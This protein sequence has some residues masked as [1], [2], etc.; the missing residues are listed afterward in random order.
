VSPP[1]P[2][3]KKSRCLSQVP[4]AETTAEAKASGTL[5]RRVEIFA[6]WL[7]IAP[8]VARLPSKLAYRAACWRGD[9]IF[10]HRPEEAAVITHNLHKFFGET[11]SPAEAERMTRE[12][13][14][15]S[16]CEVIDIMSLGSRVRPLRKLVEIRG[17]E[18]LEAAI[19][20]GKGAI[21][22]SAHLGSYESAFSMVHA[23][24]FPVTDIGQWWWNYLPGVSSA[25][26]RFWNYVHTRRIQRYRQRPNIEPWSGGIMSAMQAL[27]ALRHNEVVTITIDAAPWKNQARTVKVP[28]LGR[29]AALLPGVVTL[30]RSARAPILM[31]FVY[32][33]EDYRHQVVEISP[34]LS[35]E[36]E[37]ATVLGR[38]AAAME[39]AIS[40][41][42]AHWSIWAAVDGLSAIGLIPAE[43]SSE[44]VAVG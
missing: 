16:S 17:L 11:L 10:R 1:R 27:T 19:A 35:M 33:S 6:F 9:W 43:S 44:N 14:R 20:G 25:S 13:L 22:C 41:N 5:L 2:W 8:L 3:G 31:T 15:L 4:V 24:G 30:A 34:P 38:C 39:A 21:L 32:R 29:E 40:T 28:F 18:H 26:Q 7:V 37:P 36:G 12:F 42:Y 23:N